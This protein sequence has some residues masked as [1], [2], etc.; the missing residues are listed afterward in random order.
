MAQRQVYNSVVVSNDPRGRVHGAIIDGTPKPGTI[1]QVK[2]GVEPV[3]GR[4]T[5]TAYN[6]DAD[7]DNPAGPIAVLME[8]FNQGVGLDTAFT[9]GAWGQV[10]CP[11]PGDEL[12]C[13]LADVSGT[14]DAHTIGEV[15]MVDDGTGKLVATT[16]TPEVESFICLETLAAPTADTL[17]HVMFCG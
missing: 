10:Y 16:G 13:L 15:L 2:A 7:G 8:D 11:L 6:R 14:G 5:W 17:A 12:L 9:A 1:M 3:M 4:F